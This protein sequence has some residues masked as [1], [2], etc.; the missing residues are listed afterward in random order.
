M[1]DVAN[2]A[3]EI[4]KKDPAL[5][6]KIAFGEAKEIND[7]RAQEMFTAL[8]AKAIAE[9]DVTQIHK[10]ATNEKATAMTTELGQR[11]KALDSGEK[12][13]DPVKIIQD[14]AKTRKEATESKIGQRKVKKQVKE[15][16]AEVKKTQPKAKD[17][18]GFIRS[19]E[20]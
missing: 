5:A 19:L 10:L 15:L 12:G 18:E 11:V 3:N 7:V 1:K 14:V 16:K 13:T 4:I 20:C 6:E 8:R 2:R 17:W 9:G